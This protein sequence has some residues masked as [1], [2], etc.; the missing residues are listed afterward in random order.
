[1]LNAQ[2]TLPFEEFDAAPTHAANDNNPPV[3]EHEEYFREF[4]A[5]NPHIYK[6]IETIA[7]L[8]IAKGRKKYGMKQVFEIIRWDMNV[9]TEDADGYKLKNAM[10]PYYT[11]HFEKMNPHLAG[12]FTKAPIRKGR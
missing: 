7:L 6:L 9:T 5:N 2:M 8:E 1:M 4:H 3:N 12:F 11:R 10:A